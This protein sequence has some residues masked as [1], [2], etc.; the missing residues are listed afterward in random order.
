[1]ILRYSRRSCDSSEVKS[2]NCLVEMEAVQIEQALVDSWE[3]PSFS[4]IT[5][6]LQIIARSGGLTKHWHEILMQGSTVEAAS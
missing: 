3:P 5:R 4:R 1:M 6:V 2:V